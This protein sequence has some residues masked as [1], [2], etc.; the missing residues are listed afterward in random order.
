MSKKTQSC[1]LL[2]LTALIWGGGFIAQSAGMDYIGPWT[3]TCMR[4]IVGGIALYGLMPLLDRLRPVAD[5]CGWR[6]RKLLKGGVIC[7]IALAFASILQQTGIQYT[8]V[9]KAGFITSLYIIFVPLF[10]LVLL[11]PVKPVI[12]LSAVLAAAGLYFL[13]GTGRFSL[14][15]GD[16]YVLA[17]SVLFAIHIMIIDHYGSD[18]D[19]IRMSCIQ[20]FTAAAICTVPM[21]LWEHPSVASVLSAGKSILYA[22]AVSSGIGYTLQI[23]GQKHAD[24]SVAGL[25]LSLESV[26]S[27]ILGFLILHQALSARETLGCVIMFGAIILAQLPQKNKECSS[28]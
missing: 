28:D 13:S 21:I 8:T 17:C 10:S 4:N 23:V 1:F 22:G 2:V 19:G 7:G 27:A 14:E 24:P 16:L 26:F 15:I 9:G 5:P 20:F 11:R 6:N 3:F 25:L 18:C 12:W